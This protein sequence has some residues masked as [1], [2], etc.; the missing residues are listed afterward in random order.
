MIR[1]I[2]RLS[3]ATVIYNKKMALGELSI[4]PYL[5]TVH[6]NT[7]N[8]TIQ[9]I[10]VSLTRDYNNIHTYTQRVQIKHAWRLV[11]KHRGFGNKFYDFM[12]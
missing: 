5:T 2:T 6:F 3:T 4:N 12:S 1:K 11:L 7:S 9:S 10:S 8:D